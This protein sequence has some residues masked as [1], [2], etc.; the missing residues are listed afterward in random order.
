MQIFRVGERSSI[1]GWT[2][3][4]R[5]VTRPSSIKP[6]ILQIAGDTPQVNQFHSSSETGVKGGFALIRQW[7]LQSIF[8]GLSFGYVRGKGWGG[9]KGECGLQTPLSAI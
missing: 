5:S 2:W 4:L 7:I 8:V 3:T 9:G 1:Y 6:S